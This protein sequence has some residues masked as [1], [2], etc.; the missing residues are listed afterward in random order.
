MATEEKMVPLEEAKE[1]VRRVCARLALLHF[2]FTKTLV[3]ELGEQKGKH[4]AL[5]AIK[6]YGIRVG[7]EVKAKADAQGLSNDPANYKEDLPLYGMH[8]KIEWLEVEG[9]KRLRA[10]N[11]VMGNVWNELGEGQLGRLYCHVD[12]AKY[13]GFNPNYKLVHIKAMPDGDEYCEFAIRPTTEQERKDF[14]DKDKDW[15]YIDQ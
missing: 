10:H 15:F 12:P 14:A 5:K 1:Q 3:E 2:C 7:K 8:Q 9:E 4:L 11:C 6:D 13:M